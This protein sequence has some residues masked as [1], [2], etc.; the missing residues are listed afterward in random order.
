MKKRPMKQ[1]LAVALGFA[2]LSNTALVHPAIAAPD[3][4]TIELPAAPAW[5]YFTDKYKTNQNE[6]TTV[7][8]N[9]AYGTLS[10]FLELWTPGSSWDQGTKLRADVLDY[11]IQYVVDLAAARTAADEEM[12]YL[13]DRRGQTYG[14]TEGLGAL[15]DVY[16]TLS[17]TTTVIKDV[18][19]DATTVKYDDVG[20][21][22]KGGDSNSQLGKVVDLVGIVRGNFAS[23][24]P[25]KGFFQYMRP[26]RWVNQQE[27]TNANR[28]V[29]PTLVPAISTTPE[30]DGGFPSGHT[31]ASYLASLS[32]AYAVPERYQE[33]LTRASEMGDS[34][35]VSGMHSPLDVMGGRM[36]ATALAAAALSDPA[37]ADLKKQA[38]EQAQ[39]VLMKQTGTSEDRFADYGKNK[40][41]YFKRLT[42]GFQPIGD[43]TRAMVVPKNAEVLLE[44]R[45]PYL[46]GPQIR[47]VLATTGLPSGY[48]L[49]DD[50]EGWGRLNLFEAANGYGAFKGAVTVNMD[51]SLGGFHAE[52]LWR[53]DISGAG[54]LI[55]RGSGKL[56]LSGANTY[57]GG[58][59]IEGGTV[60]ALSASAFGT[61]SV[62]NNGGTVT[63]N[64][65]GGGT[66]TANVY[67]GSGKLTI[68]GN[69]SQSANGTLE[70]NVTAPGDTLAV[71]GSVQ[72]GGTLR[73][74]FA[75]GYVPAAGDFTVI[76]QA[77]GLSSGRFDKLETSGLPANYTAALGYRSEGVVLTLTDTTAVP[78][79]PGTTNPPSSGGGTFTPAPTPTPTA[80]VT[81]TPPTTP[82]T[83]PVTPPTQ[84]GAQ[85]PQT[86]L[87]T[88]PFRSNV[89]DPA[90]LLQS[91]T[92][93]AAGASAADGTFSDL[94]SGHWG[95][96]S[97]AKAAKLGIVGGYANG[98]FRPNAPVTRAE[99]TAMIARGFGIQPATS[100]AAFGDTRSSWA[101][102]YIGALSNLGVVAGYGDGSFKP[103]ATISRAEMAAIIAR[104]VNLGALPGTSAPAN[105]GDVRGDHWAAGVIKQAAS[106][107]LLNGSSASAFAPDQNA[108]RAEAIALIVR[109]LETDE[110]VKALLAGL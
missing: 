46:S 52:D 78:S 97:I 109:A 33:M 66:V 96:A 12:A 30:K 25:S 94:P 40:A 57:S 70:L 110:S 10:K 47:E 7:E 88:S 15:A 19:A 82:P 105:F 74:N 89:V 50:P 18:P 104:V 61:G 54:S 49:L 60:E 99:F 45:L 24:N 93:A 27:G 9:A 56:S 80:P 83:V 100:A 5:G 32:L 64:V 55:K 36:L 86:P 75:N 103:N 79:N 108:S 34:R 23:T 76:T 14:A 68:G 85:D 39:N 43:T 107:G 53:N 58:T 22:N 72:A 20:S 101:A 17:G 2:I 38:Y 26:Y 98:T 62:V 28:I 81:P 1:M 31:N 71:K 65:Y 8:T 48:P 90:A 106:A 42:Y 29:V 3:S 95:S 37:N 67:G 69:F 51:A 73:V 91:L 87:P 11:N 16:R 4:Y 6:F 77:P 13:V 84:P 35:I 63:E 59:Q 92:Q 102:G 41:D 21:T 44:T